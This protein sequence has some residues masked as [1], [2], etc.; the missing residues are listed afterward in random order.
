MAVEQQLENAYLNVAQHFFWGGGVLVFL[1][2]FGFISP[3]S[4]QGDCD[5]S[6]SETASHHVIS[7]LWHNSAV[8]VPVITPC[9]LGSAEMARVGD[10]ERPSSAVAFRGEK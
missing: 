5:A 7:L 4:C 2:F 10:K 3:S 1:V 8:K 9:N 6:A